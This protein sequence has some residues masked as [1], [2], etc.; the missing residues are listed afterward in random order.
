M[1]T[2][3]LGTQHTGDWNCIYTYLSHLGRSAISLPISSQ[4]P[5][6]WTASPWWWHGVGGCLDPI[7]VS[8]LEPAEKASWVDNPVHTP[9]HYSPFSPL[10]PAGPWGPGGPERKKKFRAQPGQPVETKL[11]RGKETVAI[12]VAPLSPVAPLTPFW[13]GE[14]G[15][16]GAP[17]APFGPVR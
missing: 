11:C 3:R 10:M 12:P 4:L 6:R 8:W 2:H 13:P 16:P 1:C 9:S 7:L 17:W 5:S 14:P 15:R